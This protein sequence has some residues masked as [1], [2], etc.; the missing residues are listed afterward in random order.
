MI[1]IDE[2][3]GHPCPTNVTGSCTAIN[4]AHHHHLQ[5]E[6]ETEKREGT[7]G[8]VIDL[9]VQVYG[10][11]IDGFIRIAK[12]WSGI[13]GIEV[14]PTDV[15]LCMI[16]MKAVRAQVSPD[17][18]DNSDDV[19]GYLDIFRKLVGEDMIHARSVTEF[20]EKKFP[21]IEVQGVPADPAVKGQEPVLLGAWTHGD[22]GRF[23]VHP[24]HRVTGYDEFDGSYDFFCPGVF[25]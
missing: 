15:P 20:I 11:P 9:R 14:N 5:P 12:V 21:L 10:D 24:P 7:V 18:S 8:E 23:T 25:G 13:L 16:G 17:Y 19:E 4:P 1:W 3:T 22:C 2:R 6:P